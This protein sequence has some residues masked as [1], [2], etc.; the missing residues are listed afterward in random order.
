MLCALEGVNPCR[1]GPPPSFSGICSLNAR[2]G[3]PSIGWSESFRGLRGELGERASDDLV[4]RCAG[5]S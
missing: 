4:R 2:S 3:A 1:G 5:D